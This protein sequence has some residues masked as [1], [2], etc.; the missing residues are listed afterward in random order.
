MGLN[1]AAWQRLCSGCWP[2]LT[3]NVAR[4]SFS[5]GSVFLLTQ[6]LGPARKMTDWAAQLTVLDLSDHLN[7]SERSLTASVI[8]QLTKIYWPCLEDLSLKHIVPSLTFSAWKVAKVGNAG[9]HGGSLGSPSAADACTGSLEALDR[10]L[11]DSRFCRMLQCLSNSLL[12]GS[13]MI[14]SCPRIMTEKGCASCSCK[15]L[16]SC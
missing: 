14:S 10:A 4:N 9:H 12:E 2:A 3:H 7:T 16:S 13:I 8:E 15:Y 6:S 1:H 5:T 11:V